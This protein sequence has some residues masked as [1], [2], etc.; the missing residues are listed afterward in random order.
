MHEKAACGA[1]HDGSTAF[2]AEDPA[3]CNRCHVETVAKP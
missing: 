3:V 1:C 2:G